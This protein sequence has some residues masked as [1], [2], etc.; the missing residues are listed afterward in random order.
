[1]AG[2]RLVLGAVALLAAC[3]AGCS[4]DEPQPADPPQVTIN[5][6]TWTVELA[7]TAAEQYRGLGGRT[8][9]AP[10]RGMLF[11]YD[12]PQILTFCMRDCHIPLDIA[13]LDAERRVVQMYT[14]SVEPDRRG[15][16][17]Y[18]SKVPAMYALEVP[19]GSLK[20]GGVKVGDQARFENVE[21][22][23]ER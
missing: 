1:M 9:L 23:A 5:D 20:R 14:M 16:T 21:T 2:G 12:E 15:T 19:A 4:G 17:P 3:A 7:V 22:D 13:F 6:T 10:G 11:V 18:G 8:N